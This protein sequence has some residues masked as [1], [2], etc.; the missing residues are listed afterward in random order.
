MDSG[1][2]LPQNLFTF[3]RERWRW[4]SYGA[5]GA[6]QIAKFNP[7]RGDPTFTLDMRLAKN[8]KIKEGINLQV[9]AQAFDLTNRA[10]YGNNFNTNIGSSGFKTASGFINPSS[11]LT[12]RSLSGEFGFRL[13]F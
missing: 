11:Q 10:N 13:S 12:A 8:V 2:P 9:I 5:I 3:K 4:S 7:L 6:S 1:F